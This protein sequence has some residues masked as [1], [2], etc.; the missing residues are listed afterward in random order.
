MLTAV[1][2]LIDLDVRYSFQSEQKMMRGVVGGR[3]KA[4]FAAVDNLDGM[5]YL[6]PSGEL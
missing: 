3:F 2:F 1:G 5:V 6:R 4:Q